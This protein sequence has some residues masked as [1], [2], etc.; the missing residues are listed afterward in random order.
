MIWFVLMCVVCK[1]GKGEKMLMW[2]GREGS[3]DTIIKC[4][5]YYYIER[6]NGKFEFVQYT[7]YE[8]YEQ[9]VL[10]D[11]KLYFCSKVDRV[12]IIIYLAIKWKT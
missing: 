6:M 1:E 2:Y 3:D 4:D 5:S 11:V 9:D 8:T 7:R 12:I 10:A